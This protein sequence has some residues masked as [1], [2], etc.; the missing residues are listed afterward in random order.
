MGISKTNDHIQIR[1]KMPNPSQEPPASSIA[2]NQDLKDMDVLC[3]FKIKIESQNLEYGITN[4]QWSLTGPCSWFWLSIFIL[5]V[6]RSSMTFKSSFLKFLSWVW[7]LDL[8]FDM[9]TGLWYNHDMNIGSLFWFWRCKE[10]LCPLSSDGELW[11]M[12]EVPDWCWSLDIDLD[13]VTGLWY[14][15]H[16][17]FGSLSGFWMCK[18]HSFKAMEDAGGSWLDV[19]VIWVLI[20]GLG[21]GWRLLTRIWHLDLDLDIVSGLR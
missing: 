5:K 7:H 14:T 16:P 15:P 3:I 21:G 2:K 12:L 10:Q 9:V 11:R 13:I 19:V 17:K 18:E 20:C 8:N 6:L 4:D 1:I